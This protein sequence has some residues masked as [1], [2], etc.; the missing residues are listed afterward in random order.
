MIN[1]VLLYTVLQTQLTVYGAGL[2]GESIYKHAFKTPAAFVFGSESHGF[3]PAVKGTIQEWIT[4][5]SVQTQRV[6]SLNIASASAIVLS[7]FTQS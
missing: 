7:T 5:P 1:F 6:E 2:E 3:S 4:I